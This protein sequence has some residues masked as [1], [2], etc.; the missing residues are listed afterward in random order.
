MSTLP[1]HREWTVSKPA[2]NSG[3]TAKDFRSQVLRCNRSCDMAVPQQVSHTTVSLLLV[4]S[5][6]DLIYVNC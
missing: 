3:S 6:V 1:Y 2:T 4:I 5:S